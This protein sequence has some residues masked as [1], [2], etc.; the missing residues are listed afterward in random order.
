MYALK[1]GDLWEGIFLAAESRRGERIYNF[2]V[3]IYVFSHLEGRISQPGNLCALFLTFAS[4]WST[5]FE[6]LLQNLNEGTFIKDYH[7]AR[8]GFKM[9]AGRVP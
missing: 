4:F 7:A 6:I 2:R 8:E 1:R 9:L 5:E 3:Y